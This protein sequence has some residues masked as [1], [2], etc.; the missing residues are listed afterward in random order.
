M[1]LQISISPATVNLGQPVTITYYSDGFADTTLTVDN[2]PNP[3]DLGG[4]TVS[5][6]MKILPLT[7]GTFNVTIKGSGID[8]GANDYL[9]EL[10]KS[11]SC[12][13]I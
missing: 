4:S 9:S 6:T 3:F 7:D 8:G 1:E 10:T 5:G 2:Y 12:N 13:V 11:A